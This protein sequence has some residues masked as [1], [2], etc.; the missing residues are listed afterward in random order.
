MTALCI[1]CGE[2]TNP[3]HRVNFSRDSI[4]PQL[5]RTQVLSLFTELLQAERTRRNIQGM[6][7]YRINSTTT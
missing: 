4:G 7:I 5:P 2:D 3:K 1:A 6:P